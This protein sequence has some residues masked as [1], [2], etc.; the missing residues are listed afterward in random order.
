MYLVFCPRTRPKTFLQ[1]FDLVQWESKAKHSRDVLGWVLGQKN[2]I[3]NRSFSHVMYCHGD[4][5]YPCL[6]VGNWNKV[7]IAKI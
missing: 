7:E 1:C 4:K 3:Q 2:K 6:L 5:S